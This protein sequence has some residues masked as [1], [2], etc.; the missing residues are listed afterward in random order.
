MVQ[1]KKNKK[2]IIFFI[3]IFFVTFF[4]VFFILL[5]QNLKNK[6]IFFINKFS[7]NFIIV[8]ENF[9][10]NNIL[11]EKFIKEFNLNKNQIHDLLVLDQTYSSKKE[12]IENLLDINNV[13]N[14]LILNEMI[15]LTEDSHQDFVNKI[16]LFEPF[17][18]EI[19]KE[20]LIDLTR[21]QLVKLLQC[22]MHIYYIMKAGLNF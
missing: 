7:Q 10:S 14:N 19:F 4:G 16:G 20:D 2:N 1:V 11:Y 17:L 22:K 9:K 6:I 13:I 15:Q 8:A 12:L 3:L 18:T 21:E 5:N